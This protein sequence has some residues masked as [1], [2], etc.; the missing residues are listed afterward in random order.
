MSDLIIYEAGIRIDGEYT[1]FMSSPDKKKVDDF[2]EIMKR[3][4]PDCSELMYIT[5]DYRLI[6]ST[7]HIVKTGDITGASDE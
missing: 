6:S 2:L 1:K 5:K 7:P 4:T 3:S